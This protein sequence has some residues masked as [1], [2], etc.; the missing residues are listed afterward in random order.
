MRKIV[1]IANFD[2]SNYTLSKNVSNLFVEYWAKRWE[3]TFHVDV[4]SRAGLKIEQI[5]SNFFDSFVNF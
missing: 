5:F 1:K 3:I 2:R 4:Y